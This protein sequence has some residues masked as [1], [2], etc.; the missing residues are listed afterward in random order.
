MR[1]IEWPF[2]GTEA[3]D[4]GSLTY[5]ELRRFHAGIYPGVWVPRGEN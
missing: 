5:R 3:V 4:S 1:T 2:H